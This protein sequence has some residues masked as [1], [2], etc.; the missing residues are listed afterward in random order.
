MH[1]VRAFLSL[2]GADERRE[3]FVTDADDVVDT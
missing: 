2:H 3:E 1:K